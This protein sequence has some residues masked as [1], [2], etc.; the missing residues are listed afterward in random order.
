M[1]RINYYDLD[2]R[3]ALKFSAFLRMV[4]IAADENATDLGVGF[5]QLMPLGMSFVL[6]RFSASAVRLPAYGEGVS[7]ATW[8]AALERGTFIRKGEMCDPEGNKLIEW[9]SLWLLF[10]I[11]ERKIL[12]PAAL[13]VQLTGI[14]DQGVALNP[15]KVDIPSGEI[16]GESGT[17]MMRHSQ[18]THRVRYADTD[19]NNHMNNAVY[20]DLAGNAVFEARAGDILNAGTL[21]D[22]WRQLHLNYLAEARPGEEINVTACK[23]NKAFYVSGEVSTAEN[24]KNRRIFTAQIQ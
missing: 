23:S 21:P 5:K 7:I 17:G 3:G 24:E 13:P 2:A 8:P 12:R 9:A 4:H 22:G 18:Y 16:S 15:Q 11:N 6:Q 10:D 20:G 19:T 1:N 14:G